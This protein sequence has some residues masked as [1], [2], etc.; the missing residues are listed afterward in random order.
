MRLERLLRDVQK[1]VDRN[2]VLVERNYNKISVFNDLYKQVLPSETRE[3]VSQRLAQLFEQ[4]LPYLRFITQ[5]PRLVGGVLLALLAGRSLIYSWLADESEKL[6]KEVLDRNTRNV[7][8]TLEGVTKDPETLSLLLGLLGDLLALPSTRSM[9][10]QATLDLLENEATRASLVELL[11]ATFKDER[12]AAQTGAFLLA[13]LDGPEAR[14]MLDEQ[15]ARLVSAAVLDAQVQADAGEGVRA[16]LRH[17]LLPRWARPAE[18]A[19]G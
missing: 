6:G 19:N 7:I 15:T 8:A 4:A 16:T 5:A 11:V 3:A 13:S 18:R 2:A 1:S 17:A 14:R 9:L 10:V 12:L